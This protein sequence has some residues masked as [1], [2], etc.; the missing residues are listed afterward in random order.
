MRLGFTFTPVDTS[1]DDGPVDR[2][3]DF[4]DARTIEAIAAEL[5]KLCDEVVL[6]PFDRNVVGALCDTHCDFVFNISEGRSGRNRESQVPALLEVLEIPYS[7]SD[8]LTLG[9]TQD[10]TVAKQLARGL[11]V[12]TPAFL[13]VRRLSDLSDGLPLPA[14]LPL[15]V[16]PNH[17]G[18]SKGVRIS[19]LVGDRRQL[20]KQ[21]QWLLETY[22]Q[23][24][25]VEQFLEG[26]EFAVGLLGTDKPRIFPITEIVVRDNGRRVPFYS[27]E[28]KGR[29]AKVL[30]CPADIPDALV[31]ELR[32]MAEVLYAGFGVREYGR[33]DF[34]LDSEGVPYFLEMNAL[35]GLS[36][37][38]G[39]YT[40]CANT[41]GC[42]YHD[43]IRQ[44]LTGGL[45][46]A[47]MPNAEC[48]MPTD[49]EADR[50]SKRGGGS[51]Q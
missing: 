15:F 30:I 18:S 37:E 1:T 46:R 3:A 43:L 32:Q 20:G 22:R 31:D 50:V 4:E 16:K 28:W 10:K 23:P 48:R 24:V 35:P 25:L 47:G 27:Y 5:A 12:R 14:D 13:Q 17:E 49:S 36:P 9:I 45:E 44:I 42:S 19:S 7:G 38:F 21:V 51:D 39:I 34:K 8:P 33:V 26:R 29:H 41:A 11:G 2:E 6:I 40:R